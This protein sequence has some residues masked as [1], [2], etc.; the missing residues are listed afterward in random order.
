[1]SSDKK[2][3][4]VPWQGLLALAVA[5]VGT[6]YYLSPLDTSRPVERNGD[7]LRLERERN[8]NSRLWQDPLVA[9]YTREAQIQAIDPSR[10]GQEF[11]KEY[12]R[13]RSCNLANLIKAKTSKDKNGLKI[14]EVIVPGGSYAEYGET[15]LRLR[16]AVLEALGMNRFIPTDGE[17]IDYI[18]VPWPQNMTSKDEMLIPFEWCEPMFGKSTVPP[19][20][21]SGRILVLWL[22]DEAFESK[23]LTGLVNLHSTLDIHPQETPVK[24]LGPRSSEGLRGLVSEVIES[25]PH[26]EL[27]K[28]ISIFSGTATASEELLLHGKVKEGEYEY[29]Q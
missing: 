25:P 15:R 24:V 17:H 27:L 11:E 9:A 5:A 26:N 10:R 7:S 28:G 8:V 29:C 4:Q 19:D 1:M 18:R 6:F 14:L 12:G 20:E 22:R 2:D 3:V 13:H 23:M 16:R 21:F